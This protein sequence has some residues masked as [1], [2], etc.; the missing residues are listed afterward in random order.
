MYLGSSKTSG[1]G[2][3]DNEEILL[4]Q[5]TKYLLRIIE[6]NIA[7]TNINWVLDWYEHTNII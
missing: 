3:R 6:P 5:N 7:A 1:G 2:V 4:K